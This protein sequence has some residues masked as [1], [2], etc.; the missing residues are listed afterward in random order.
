M[1]LEDGVSAALN[2]SGDGGLG[3]GVH[4]RSRRP[5][6]SILPP[7]DTPRKGTL[8]KAR[9]DLIRV[10]PSVFRRD[11]AHE[12]DEPPGPGVT[13]NVAQMCV[14]GQKIL[15]DDAVMPAIDTVAPQDAVGESLSA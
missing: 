15:V 6:I 3:E 9:S 4:P 14:A 8:I 5:W 7:I 10:S 13:L 12:I 11:T 1:G 2:K